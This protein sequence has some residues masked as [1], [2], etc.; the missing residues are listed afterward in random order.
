MPYLVQEQG[1]EDRGGETEEKVVKT[2][3]EGI[4]H[5][6]EKVGTPEEPD[7][8]L[9]AHPGTSGKAP[10]GGKVLKGDKG[11]VHGLV[12]EKGVKKDNRYS[13]NVETPVPLHILTENG[14]YPVHVD[15]S[16]KYGLPVFSGKPALV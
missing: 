13:E 8:M 7:K 10:A 12:A 15:T 2:D 1:K 6:A 4:P 14:W 11:P 9:K 16:K 5:Q 3:E